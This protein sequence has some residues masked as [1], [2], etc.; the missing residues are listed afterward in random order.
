M[1]S[2]TQKKQKEVPYQNVTVTV[3]VTVSVSV[4]G[5]VIGKNARGVFCWANIGHCMDRKDL[6]FASFSLH[7]LRCPAS[8]QTNPRG[9]DNYMRSKTTFGQ[10]FK[11]DIKEKRSSFVL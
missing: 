1:S 10:N 2:F 11:Y 4:T 8:F 6:F 5:T 9:K 7:S 3:T